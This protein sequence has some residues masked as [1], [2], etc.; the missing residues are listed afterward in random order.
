MGWEWVE[1]GLGVGWGRV[2]GEV[3]VEVCGNVGEMGL[4]EDEKEGRRRREKERVWNERRRREKKREGEE[5][6]EEKGV[7][8]K[9]EDM[10]QQKIE[11]ESKGREQKGKE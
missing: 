8:E 10:E 5:K 6:G 7:G 1:S 4:K 9:G 3:W 2:G 11:G